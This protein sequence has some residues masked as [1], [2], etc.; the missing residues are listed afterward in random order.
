MIHGRGQWQHKMSNIWVPSQPGPSATGG[1]TYGGGGTYTAANIIGRSPLDQ[2]RMSRGSVPHAEYP[3]GYLGTITDRHQDKLLSA[4]QDKLNDR[5][6]QRGDHVG[7][8][9][10]PTDYYWPAGFSPD[11]RLRAES[12][13]TQEGYVQ[14]IPRYAPRG[15]PVERLAHLGKT[16]GLTPPEQ[17]Q[18]YKQFGVSMAKNPVVN[19]DP[20]RAAR[21]SKMLPS[22]ARTM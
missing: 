10:A 3:D 12:R 18:V 21:L 5:S 9:V 13:Y 17:Q 7:S 14:V 6:Y 4:V 20:T 2:Q 15:N 19:Q 11:S 1:T 16:A 8:R 22:Y